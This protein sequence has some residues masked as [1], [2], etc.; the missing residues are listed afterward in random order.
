MCACRCYASVERGY[1]DTPN[2]LDWKV[3]HMSRKTVKVAE[4]LRSANTRLGVPDMARPHLDKLT[5]HQAFRL[6]VASVLEDMLHAS[7]TYAG[8]GYA[9]DTYIAGTT[10]ETQRVYRVHQTLSTEG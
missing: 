2:R 9:D 4:V 8:Y 7:D 5:P 1:P 10:D 6:G 3:S